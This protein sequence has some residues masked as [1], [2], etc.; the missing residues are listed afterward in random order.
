MCTEDGYRCTGANGTSSTS[1]C[2]IGLAQESV[3]V[4]KDVC[5]KRVEDLLTD[6]TQPPASVALDTDSV[7]FQLFLAGVM[8]LW[9]ST[10]CGI[11]SGPLV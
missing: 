3:T 1:S 2:T 6:L 5:V 4:F 8:Q 7:F 11:S 10:D 9:C